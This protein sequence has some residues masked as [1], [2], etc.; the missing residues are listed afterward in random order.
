M[1]RFGIRIAAGVVFH[2]YLDLGDLTGIMGI[3]DRGD[4]YLIRHAY[5]RTSCHR[6][7]IGGRLLRFLQRDAGKPLLVGTWSDAVWAVAFYEKNGFHKVP[8]Q[9]KDDLLRKYWSIPER[10]I[11]TSVV[12]A[13]AA[14][15]EAD[16]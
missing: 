2:G 8:S 10:Q 14:W 13:N 5:V 15:H 12:L 16:G 7:G 6:R 9:V 3:Q 11:D 1:N 4:V